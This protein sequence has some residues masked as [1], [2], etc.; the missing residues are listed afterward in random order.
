[1]HPHQTS[2]ISPSRQLYQVHTRSLLHFHL[3]STR[4]SQ[5][6][7]SGWL[8]QGADRGPTQPE[9][10]GNLRVFQNIEGSAAKSNS[11]TIKKGLL[12]QM[13]SITLRPRRPPKSSVVLQPRPTATTPPSTFPPGRG[14]LPAT[15]EALL[16][17]LKNLQISCKFSTPNATRTSLFR[18]L[19]VSPATYETV[20]TGG[21]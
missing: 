18:L 9:L 16:V 7:A 20:P 5:C 15:G 8:Q 13:P 19:A 10:A 4:F 12:T 1:M 14:I 11:T 2:P 6:R 21:S 17:L 3:T